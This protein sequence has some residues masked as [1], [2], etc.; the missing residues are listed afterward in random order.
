MCDIDGFTL[1]PISGVG[2]DGPVEHDA[3]WYTEE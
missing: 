2:V 3:E 1:E